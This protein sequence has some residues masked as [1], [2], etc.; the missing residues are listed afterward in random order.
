MCKPCSTAI[1]NRPAD[2]ARQDMRPRLPTHCPSPDPRRC[3]SRVRTCAPAAARSPDP[4]V[5]RKIPRSN[6]RR[7]G[8]HCPQRR[9][10]QNS[11]APF[12][13]HQGWLRRPQT[14]GPPKP[15]S[16][17]ARRWPY[18]GN[19]ACNNL[20]RNRRE[21][22]KAAFSVDSR[23]NNGSLLTEQ[24]DAHKA[25]PFVQNALTCRSTCQSGYRVGRV[26][27]PLRHLDGRRRN[28]LDGG[29]DS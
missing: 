24:I 28:L 7:A 10:L 17:D 4:S 5:G 20:S 6:Q 13:S 19:A 18:R 27:R 16:A 26:Q 1:F 25:R 3:C 9:R 11:G 12:S 22:L 8:R 23:A 14:A 21:H 15:L 2:R 29:K